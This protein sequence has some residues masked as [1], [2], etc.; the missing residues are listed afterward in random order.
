MNM[1]EIN[2]KELRKFGLTIAFAIAVPFGGIFPL[3]F[4]RAL[5]FWPWVI[6]VVLISGAIVRPN[7]MIII[8]K[9]WMCLSGILGTINTYVV[10][11]VIFYLVFTPLSIVMKIVRRDPLKRKFDSKVSTYR[12]FTKRRDK[13]HMERSF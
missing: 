10:L 4:H 12:C 11:S 9:P 6:F 2:K 1:S 3:V 8:Y 7:T 5:P 13:N